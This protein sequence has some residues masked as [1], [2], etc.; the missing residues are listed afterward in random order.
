MKFLRIMLAIGIL[1][2]GITYAQKENSTIKA[3]KV[4]KQSG[5]KVTSPSQDGWQIVKAESSET[6]FSKT[7]S[8]EKFNVFVKTKTISDYEKVEDLFKNLEET[9]QAELDMPN[10][11]SLHFNQTDYKNTP[12]LQYDGIFNNDAAKMPGYKYFNFYGYLC[13]H[14]NDKKIVIQMEFS[15][16]SN[17]RGF[18]ETEGKLAK[19]FLEKI[20]FSKVKN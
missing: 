2:A 11:D 15:N 1:F 10:R 14:P 16:Y 3:G 13:R 5:A 17:S 19:D 12:C 8:D 6:I 4:Y 18:S 9:K 7:T 20:Q